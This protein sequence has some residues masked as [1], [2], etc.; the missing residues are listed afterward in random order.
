MRQ[1]VAGPHPGDPLSLPAEDVDYPAAA[2]GGLRGKRAAFCRT[3]G[4]TPI[5]PDVAAVVA[6]AVRQLDEAGVAVDEVEIDLGAS[7]ERLLESWK[8]GASMGYVAAVE[9]MRRQGVDLLAELS[10]EVSQSFAPYVRRGH[11]LTA[12]E[13]RMEN[14]LRTG[15]FDAF[16]G[17]FA[18][19]DFILSP[20]LAVAGVDNVVGGETVGPTS[21]NGVAIDPV[22][23]WTLCFPA[24]FT[25]HPAAS[26][27]AG[28]TD[29]NLP[30]G[31]QIVGRRFRD[32]EVLA[33]SGVLERAKPWY[34][35]YRSRLAVSV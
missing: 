24:N 23:G 8:R 28:F 27:P 26:I 33:V 9:T 15:V 12:L 25:G 4:E 6:D 1:V 21:V 10:E 16:Q 22:G 17:V 19:Y 32:D 20:T 35:G 5:S 2:R 30:V 31:L 18:D 13:H 3:F 14:A 34:E 7:T 29:E 11:D